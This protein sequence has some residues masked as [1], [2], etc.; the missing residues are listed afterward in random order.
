[1]TSCGHVSNDRCLWGVAGHYFGPT[2][3]LREEVTVDGWMHKALTVHTPV[4]FCKPQPILSALSS[5]NITIKTS[6]ARVD[7]VGKSLHATFL[8]VVNSLH[9]EATK[10]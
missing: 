5:L 4:P 6:F 7:V 10:F 3:P 2:K 9:M 8:L 1:M